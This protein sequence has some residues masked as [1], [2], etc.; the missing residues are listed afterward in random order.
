MTNVAAE[1][2]AFEAWYAKRHP[3]PTHE[4]STWAH[5][6]KMDDWEV[7]QARAGA[8]P[9]AVAP[10][11]E[12][13]WIC[14][15]RTVADLVN[16]LLTMDQAL[17]I[18][19]AQYIERDG[20]RCAIAVP[21]TV[22]RER[23]KDGRWIGQGEELNAAVVWTRA[24]QP[25]AVTGPDHPLGRIYPSTEQDGHRC[26]G[27][28]RTFAEASQEAPGDTSCVYCGNDDW[29][30]PA[31]PAL[32]APAA[33]ESAPWCPDVC[34]ITGRPFFMW[35]THHETGVKVPTYGGP[36]DSY[37]L[38]VKGSDGSFECERYD[39]DRG[40]WLTDEIQDVGLTLVDDQSF[41]VAPDHPR[42]TEVEEFANG[43]ATL[44]AAK[45]GSMIAVPFDLIASACSAIDKKRD[46]PKTL[47]ELRRYTTGDLS[48]ALEAP[49][50]PA[51]EALRALMSLVRR[52]APHLSGKVM[53]DA[54]AI[55]A[56]AALAAAPQA[57][58]LGEDA[59]HLLHRLLSNQHTLTGPEFRAELEKIVAEESARH[60]AAPQAPAAPM[61]DLAQ[62]VKQLVRALRKA[63]PGND[64][65]DK[66]LD[67]LKRQGLQGS[68]LRA[69]PE[70]PQTHAG[71]L[72][73]AAHI[74]AKAQAHL[75]ERGSYDPDTGAVE[76]SESNQEHFNTLD[77]LAEEIRLMADKAAP[78]SCDKPPAGWTCSRASGHDGPCA[79]APAAPAVDAQA[80]RDTAFEAVRKRLCG[81]P[82]YSFVLDDDGVVRREQDRIGNWIEFDD[83]HE[84]FDPVAVDAA[85]AA[86]AKEGGGA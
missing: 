65:A 52:E 80:E 50:D 48:R 28:S 31:A 21:P 78:A 79:A 59:L 86:Q 83:A 81:L 70:A 57:P 67:Y 37:T 47:A 12:R 13:Q 72:A 22:S 75:D 7:W 36:F 45:P 5:C 16:N 24:E 17:P 46:A 23:V 6:A 30:E 9:A 29:R 11:G 63:A 27:C 33:P 8:A 43:A 49:A 2:D 20:R 40:G 32:E 85:I 82:R 77:E 74:Q 53:G 39:H 64:L 66:A 60:A 18:Y 73:A 14:P 58:R 26:A 55:L 71:L 68:P 54:D 76:M 35:I 84:L 25:A 4:N 38:P 51:V 15:T 61:D 19:G 44:A 56:G 3:K 62:L 69:T 42:Y 10:Q 1:R 34:P 41:I